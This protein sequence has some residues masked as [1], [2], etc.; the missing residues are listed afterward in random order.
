[1]DDLH[2]FHNDGSGDGRYPPYALRT[3]MN[4]AHTAEA[5]DAH[6]QAAAPLSPEQ[7]HTNA[8]VYVEGA[9]C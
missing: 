3:P 7:L 6:P 4:V 5:A 9:L 8:D 2:D 1:M